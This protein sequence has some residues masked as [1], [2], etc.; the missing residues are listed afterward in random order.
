MNRLNLIL[1]VFAGAL[2][3]SCSSIKVVTDQDTTT[4]FSKYKTIS[5]LG[6]QDNSGVLL[7][8]IDRERLR[9]AFMNEFGARNL[10]YQEEGGDMT[11]SL[12][13]VVDVETDT[14]AYAKYWSNYGGMYGG[15]YDGGWGGDLST[16]T[17]EK[18]DYLVGTLVM[19]V[20]DKASG[21][22][23][24]QAVAA[25]TINENPEKRE[26]SIPKVIG[27]LMKKFPLEPVE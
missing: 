4:D 5:F 15:R 25:K 24:W 11:I 21:D 16:T 14:S 22:Q 2:L 26:K 9:D 20:F 10:K 27:A 6:W 17:Y 12:F 7:D 3:L 18:S 13:L 8:E 23:I 1:T 19:D